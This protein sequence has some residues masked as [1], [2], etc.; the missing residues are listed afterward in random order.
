MHSFNTM[1]AWSGFSV[2]EIIFL[3]FS[4][5]MECHTLRHFS[6]ISENTVLISATDK[7]NHYR[8]FH[9]T[10]TCSDHE[11]RKAKA[12]GCQRQPLKSPNLLYGLFVIDFEN[13]S[14]EALLSPTCNMRKITSKTGHNFI[15]KCTNSFGYE[16]QFVKF[17]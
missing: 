13:T 14:H 6:Y 2:W 4:A 10:G 7:R 16:L 3:Y 8:N 11:V 9:C 5:M 17:V 15:R 1:A 12:L